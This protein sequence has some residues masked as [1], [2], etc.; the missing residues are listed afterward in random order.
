MSKKSNHTPSSTLN[1]HT[2]HN[3][4]HHCAANST[5]KA[6]GKGNPKY[7]SDP[8]AASKPTGSVTFWNQGCKT[9][10]GKQTCYPSV[11]ITQHS[12]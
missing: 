12:W 4:C 6:V 5:L 10:N 11:I 8:K 2:S 3:G 9:E 7:P 1:L